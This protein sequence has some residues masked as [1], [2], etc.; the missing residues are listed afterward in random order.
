MDPRNEEEIFEVEI[1]SKQIQVITAE[2]E[3]QAELKGLKYL[4]FKHSWISAT[5]GIGL[6]IGSLFVI[7]VSSWTRFLTTDT[8]EVGG[9]EEDINCNDP[10][11]E[12]AESSSTNVEEEEITED[13]PDENIM[14]QPV[15]D[16]LLNRNIIL[17]SQLIPSIPSIIFFMKCSLQLVLLFVFFTVSYHAYTHVYEPSKLMDILSSEMFSCLQCDSSGVL[18]TAMEFMSSLYYAVM[19]WDDVFV[20]LF[21]IKIVFAVMLILIMSMTRFID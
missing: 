19:D 10:D 21:V 6:T 16:G 9:E 15:K 1:K 2:L 18:Q 4:M 3:V 5:I 17:R 8:G 11:Q 12:N 20:K 7:I 14:T 13:K